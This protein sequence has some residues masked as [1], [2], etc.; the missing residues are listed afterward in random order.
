M[1]Y[2]QAWQVHLSIAVKEYIQVE[3][4]GPPS[5]FAGAVSTPPSLDVEQGF[6][7]LAGGER[8]FEQSGGVEIGALIDGTDGGGFRDG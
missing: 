7:K 1:G 5:L 3:G 2:L 4:P 6:E 8:C